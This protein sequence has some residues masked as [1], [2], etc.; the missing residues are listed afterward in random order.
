MK[1][2]YFILFIVVI[3]M[4]RVQMNA[5]VFGYPGATWV[6]SSPYMAGVCFEYYEKWEYVQDTTILGVPVKDIFITGHLIL[7]PPFPNGQ[8]SF[9]HQYF[10]LNGDTVWLFVKSDSTWQELYN[11]SVQ[12]GDTV[13]N[14]MGNKLNYWAVECSDS[15]PYNDVALVTDAGIVNVSGQMLRYY[16]IHYYTGWMNDSAYQTY[17]E[18]IIT[19]SYWHPSDNFWCGAVA[20]CF[21]PGLV[22]YKDNGMMT[23]SI[24]N[25]LSWFETVSLEENIEQPGIKIYPNP[26]QDILFINSPQGDTEKYMVFSVDGKLILPNLQ[27]PVPVS[28]LPPGI[29]FLTDKNKSRYYK[30]IKN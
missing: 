17:Y 8:T 25:D 26:V 14:P 4:G 24:C 12:I 22:C 11:F 20:E 13:M 1:K 6:F 16:T 29:Y 23:D 21:T 5:Q 28:H 3:C 15:I 7:P 18:R 9:D 27:S 10:K 19:G 30:F 2:L